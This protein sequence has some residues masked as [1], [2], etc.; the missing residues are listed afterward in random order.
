MDAL[1]P[2]KIPIASLKADHA[3][4]TWELGSDFLKLFDDEHESEKG[5]FSVIMELTRTGLV[6]TLEFIISGIVDTI[7]DRCTALIAMPIDSTYEI[8]VKFGDP[9]DTTDEVIFI[10][11]EA[12]GLNVGQH[13]YDFILLSIP[14]SRRIP[15]CEDMENRP[16]DETVLAY[17]LEKNELNGKDPDDDSIWEDL[18]KVTDN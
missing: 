3:R 13:I 7:C 4:Y 9:A 10:D 18:R 17:L 5:R 1:A 2:F 12:H 8:I 6:T 15:G 14:I 16:C 11:P